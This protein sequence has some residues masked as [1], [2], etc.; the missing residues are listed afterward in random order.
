MEQNLD[1]VCKL[2]KTYQGKDKMLRCVQYLCRF[3]RGWM[4]SRT[5]DLVLGQSVEMIKSKNWSLFKVL[6]NARRAFRW[7]GSIPSILALYRL[8]KTDSCAW[9]EKNVILFTLNKIFM[10]L[11]PLID[12]YRF[13]ILAK[14]TKRHTQAQVRNVAFAFLCMAQI[15]KSVAMIRLRSET[16]DRKKRQQY[17]WDFTKAFLGVVCIAHVSEFPILRHFT[18]ELLCGIS[19]SVHSAMDVYD[20]WRKTAPAPPKRPTKKYD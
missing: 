18:N 8:V 1:R 4:E 3:N 7:F 14:W 19:G 17:E 13:F 12:H 9:G 20:V 5:G 2:L 16:K 15:C 10:V 11:F 6:M